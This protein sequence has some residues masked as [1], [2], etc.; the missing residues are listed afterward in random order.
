MGT[1]CPIRSPGTTLDGARGGPISPAS[2]AGDP[3]GRS[4]GPE[5]LRRHHHPASEPF[6]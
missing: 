4:E 5:L 3:A 6:K 1:G 2:K